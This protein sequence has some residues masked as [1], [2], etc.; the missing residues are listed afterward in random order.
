MAQIESLSDPAARR[1]SHA[2]DA[3][4]LLRLIDD[5]LQP[6][7]IGVEDECCEVVGS[8]VRPQTWTAIL[9][10]AVRERGAVECGDRIAARRHECQMKAGT[11][12]DSAFFRQLDRQFVSAAGITVADRCAVSPH[13]YISQGAQHGVVEFR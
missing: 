5:G 13:S 11:H 9:L 8:V 12:S 7:T 4:A 3:S 10:S 1:S 6:M 2:T